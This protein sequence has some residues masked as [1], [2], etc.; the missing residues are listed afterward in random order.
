MVTES[1]EK[2]MSAQ[3]Q[4]GLALL[5][6]GRG[7][8]EVAGLVGVTPETVSRWRG[9]AEFAAALRDAQAGARQEAADRL[10]GMVERAL[11]VLGVE[12]E[13]G[14]IRASLFVLASVGL[15]RLVASP[16]EAAKSRERG[17]ADGEREMEERELS[18]LLRL[19]DAAL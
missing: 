16:V 2:K 7:R 13:R 6:A 3:Q 15:D 14:S 12:L 8:A 5:I 18:E 10:A 4:A 1:H 11:D 9:Q 17:H 19:A